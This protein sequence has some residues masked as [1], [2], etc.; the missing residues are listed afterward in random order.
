ML[1]PWFSCLL[2]ACRARSERVPAARQ[3]A[4]MNACMQ[5]CIHT[6][7][8]RHEC[9]CSV[10]CPVLDVVLVVQHWATKQ[11]HRE[12]HHTPTANIVCVVNRACCTPAQVLPTSL[13]QL[14][15]S[16]ETNELGEDPGPD[17]GPDQEWHDWVTP[18][19]D[20]L[21]RLTGAGGGGVCVWGGGP[22]C[23]CTRRA[24]IMT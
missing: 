9:A 21:A 6:T 22:A 14:R 23:T 20:G 18:L 7:A 16:C 24:S 5:T 12:V 11:R 2:E 1:G 8:C 13:T 15:L 10:T 19:V 4:C 3:A 17:D